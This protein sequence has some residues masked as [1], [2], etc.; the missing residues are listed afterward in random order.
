[1]V[2]SWYNLATVKILGKSVSRKFQC[3]YKDVKGRIRVPIQ[4]E[5]HPFRAMGEYRLE[6]GIAKI[7]LNTNLDKPHFEY[8][9]A[10]ELV[11]VLKDS[12]LWPTTV[13][14]ANLPDKSP[15]ALVGS[16]LLALVRD[17]SDNDNLKVAGFDSSY[18]DDIRYRNSKKALNKDPV[19]HIGTPDWCIW[20]I[21]YCYLSM[22]QSRR[23]WNELREIYF[24]R[25][26]GIAEKGEELRNIMQ[27]HGWGD[28][29]Q[30]LKSLIAIRNS[31]GLTKA[32]VIIV[33]RRT[34]ENF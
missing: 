2:S 17:L 8:T 21:R 13:R 30:A 15:E 22:T 11:H 3:F 26:P 24:K 18:S 31:L 19:P 27:K 14:H 7:R 29:D 28:P 4:F 10:H 16:E 20:V 34:G 33:D 12:E 32:Q 1:M 9:A 25:A 5:R 6:N 23:R